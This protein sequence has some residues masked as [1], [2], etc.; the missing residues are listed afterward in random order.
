LLYISTARLA[1]SNK[2]KAFAKALYSSLKLQAQPMIN[3]IK[4]IKAD[5]NKARLP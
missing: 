4:N 3:G 1:F 2:Y 5:G